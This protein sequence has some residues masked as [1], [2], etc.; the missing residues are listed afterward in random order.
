MRE[1][2]QAHKLNPT[3]LA[4]AEVVRSLFSEFL[5]ALEASVPSGR[6]RA[7]VVTKLQEAAFFAVSGVAT[8]AEN[9]DL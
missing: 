7:L 8:I 2:F 9:Y 6:N 5:T 3:G 1:E 4:K